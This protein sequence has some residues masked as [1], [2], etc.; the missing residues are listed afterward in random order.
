[1]YRRSSH[2]PPEMS[3]VPRVRKFLLLG[4]SE[5]RELQ[6][7]LP[8]YR[9]NLMGNLLIVSV[10]ASNGASTQFFVLMAMSFNSYTVICIPMRYE[11]P[12]KPG[13]CRKM[14]VNSW[15]SGGLF[16]VL[17]STSTFSLSFCGFHVVHHF[18]WDLPSLLKITC[19]EDHSSNDVSVIFD[20]TIGVFSYLKPLSHYSSVFD[21]LM[22]VFNAVMPSIMNPLIYSLRNQVLKAARWTVLKRCFPQTPL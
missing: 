4:L 14:A 6:L 20:L 21:L 16:G 2:Q 15:L 9:G 19:S 1:M 13:V 12:I 17:R 5:V 7:F 10:A 18:F 22:F 8:V 3:N 11:V